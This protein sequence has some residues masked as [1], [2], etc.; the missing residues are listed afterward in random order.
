[1][2]NVFFSSTN[3]VGRYGKKLYVHQFSSSKAEKIWQ[4]VRIQDLILSVNVSISKD[5][6][7]M[8]NT[9]IVDHKFLDSISFISFLCHT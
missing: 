7:L 3:L 8:K 1:V 6:S 4:A 9:F 2:N 5:E